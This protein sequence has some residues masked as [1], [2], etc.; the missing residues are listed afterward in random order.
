MQLT[1]ALSDTQAQVAELSKQEPK[2]SLADIAQRLNVSEG[3]ATLALPE[4]YLFATQ[5]SHAQ[6]ILEQLPEWGK[7]T[8]I[9]HSGG[10]IFE[11]KA[12][13]PTGKPA[14]GYYNLMGGNNGELHGHLKLGRVTDIAFVSKPFHGMESY[15]IG[16]YEES[17]NCIFKVYLGRDKKR[18]LFPQQIE[19]FHELQKELG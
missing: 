18:Q 7:L 3:E 16:F 6:W 13:F 17:G 14:H 2:I 1:Q 10:S 8:T 15:F 5:G 4:H 19:R 9:I 12:P 11:I